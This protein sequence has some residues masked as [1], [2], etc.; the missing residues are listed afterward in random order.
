ML[1]P[2]TTI[3]QLRQ[4]GVPNLYLFEATLESVAT[5][6][7]SSEGKTTYSAKTVY[8]YKI[9][10]VASGALVYTGQDQNSGSST[11]GYDDA[12][13]SSYYLVDAHIRNMVQD[14]FRVSAEIKAINETHPKKGIISVYLGAGS[15]DGLTS[16]NY[17]DILKVMEVAGEEI[18]EKIG[19]LK[20]TEVKSGTLS[21]CKVTKGGKELQKAMDNDVP[22]KVVSRPSGLLEF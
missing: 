2:E 5:S 17:F 19:S 9:Y 21:L 3:D 16:G 15:N 11:K 12:V 6:S 18:T 8:N 22:I 7:S 13:V 4:V 20:V 1:S 14:A 10:E